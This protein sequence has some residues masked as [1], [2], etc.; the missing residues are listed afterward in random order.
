[1]P[2]VTLL[3]PLGA[4]FSYCEL[5]PTATGVL[6]PL[7]VALSPALLRN[8][9]PRLLRGRT[10]VPLRLLLV[11]LRGHPLALLWTPLLAPR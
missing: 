5:G 1:M 2:L 9:F 3:A 4:T 8:G 10:H 7:F 6:S 11:S